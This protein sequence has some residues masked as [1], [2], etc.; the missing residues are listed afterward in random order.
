[1]L[2]TNHMLVK[3]LLALSQ[4]A[5]TTEPQQLNQNTKLTGEMSSQILSSPSDRTLDLAA[6]RRS[7]DI[8]RK[9]DQ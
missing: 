7:P 1:M 3:P 5:A 6:V 8:W 2:M 4:L 9:A